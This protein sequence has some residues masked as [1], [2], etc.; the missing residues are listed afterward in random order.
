MIHHGDSDNGICLGHVKQTHVG[1][2]PGSVHMLELHN[3]PERV[4]ERREVEGGGG[5]R[6]SDVEIHRVRE[7]VGDKG[8]RDMGGQGERE[9][10]EKGEQE[11]KSASERLLV[12]VLCDY[13]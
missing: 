1:T 2:S 6:Q 10:G 13:W 9:R 11:G 7:R 8:K 12:S 4:R 3:H 5:W